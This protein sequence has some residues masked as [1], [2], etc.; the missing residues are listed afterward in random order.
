MRNAHSKTFNKARNTEKT[1]KMKNEKCT[2]Q[3]LEYG[4]KTEKLAK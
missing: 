4:E 1:W 3:Y 2:L